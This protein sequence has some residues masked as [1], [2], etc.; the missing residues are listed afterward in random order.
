[1]VCILQVRRLCA[2]VIGSV[3]S[4]EL[5]CAFVVNVV[6]SAVDRTTHQNNII[7]PISFDHQTFI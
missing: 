4:A 1:M 2:R 6:T 7:S 5:G 3:G